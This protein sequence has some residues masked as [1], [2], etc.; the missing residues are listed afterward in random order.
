V[1]KDVLGRRPDGAPDPDGSD[2]VGTETLFEVLGNR[3]RRH[4]IDVLR[5]RGGRVALDRLAEEVAAR[6]N[7]LDRTEISAVQ[8]KRVYT[9][10]QQTHLPKMD[11]ADV[12]TFDKTAGTV[13]PSAAIDEFTVYLDVVPPRRLP[14][15]AIYLGLAGLSTLVALG[16]WFDLPPVARVTP[17][18]WIGVVIA[19]FAVVA[20]HQRFRHPPGGNG[21]A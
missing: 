15:G 14:R 19:T 12:L 20:G 11:N 1:L 10:L 16:V 17:L 6:E 7:G 21:G 4:V 8:R 13:A 9:A 5:Q 2:G 3:R 18:V